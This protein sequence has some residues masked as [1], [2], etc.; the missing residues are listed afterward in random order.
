MMILT[1]RFAQRI[2]VRDNLGSLLLR[3][4]KLKA[5]PTN[6]EQVKQARNLC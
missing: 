4:N 2:E 6:F 5:Q 1:I 3:E